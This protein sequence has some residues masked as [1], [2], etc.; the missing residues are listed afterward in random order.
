MVV[1]T[2][3]SK[4]AAAGVANLMKTLNLRKRGQPDKVKKEQIGPNALGGQS[5][6]TSI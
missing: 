2:R 4:V 6:L 3:K 1:E 5:S